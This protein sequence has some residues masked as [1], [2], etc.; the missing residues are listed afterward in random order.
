MKFIIE[1]YSTEFT[2]EPLYFTECLNKIGCETVLWN[3]KEIST[4]DI[5]DIV[6]PDVIVASLASITLDL[7]K[8]LRGKGNTELI[9]NVS[10]ASQNEIS[11]LEEAVKVN[12]I[13]CPLIF[14]DGV[15]DQYKT[16]LKYLHILKGADIFLQNQDNRLPDYS[17]DKAFMIEED[18]EIASSGSYHVVGLRKDIKADIMVPVSAFYQI[19]KNYKKIIFKKTNTALS[20]FFF[21]AHFY[22]NNISVETGG[23]NKEEID[24]ILNTYFDGDVQQSVKTRHTCTRRVARWL[25]KL[26]CKDESRKVRNVKAKEENA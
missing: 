5:Y 11:A 26:G 14:G 20:Q 21:D 9:I 3:P 24:K 25:Q 4:F 6:A 19:C 15:G 17:I 7:F 2:T 23:E 10:E 22:G 8:V 16:N 18:D 13:N 12:G 1:N